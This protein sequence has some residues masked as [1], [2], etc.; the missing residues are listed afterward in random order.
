MSTDLDATRIVRSWLRTDEHESA[1][2]L[3]DN[4]LALLD[5]T[6][7]HRA[8]WPVRRFAHMNSYAKLAVAAVAV[9]AVALVGINLLPRSSSSVGGAG[10]APSPSASPSATPTPLPSPSQSPASAGWP[11][12]TLLDQ[13]Y[14]ATTSSGGRETNEPRN[15][16]IAQN[17]QRRSQPEASLR[18]ATGPSVSRARGIQAWPGTATSA[19]AAGR[20]T[21]EIGSSVRRSTGT[22]GS[23]AC[24]PRRSPRRSCDPPSAPTPRRGC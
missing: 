20:C 22:C 23:G 12:G 9:V 6:P 2:R 7:Q 19:D 5:A 18:L 1:D 14:P 8:P 3:L 10:P 11:I 24:P 15:D 21:G 16:G 13:R 17:V 4:V